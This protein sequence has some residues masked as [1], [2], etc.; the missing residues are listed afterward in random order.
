MSITLLCQI[1]LPVIGL[2][3]PLLILLG[4][5]GTWL[6]LALAGLAE[7]I[8]EPRLFGTPVLVIAVALAVAGEVWEALSSSVRARRAGAGRRGS[9]GALAGG[10]G[11]ALLGTML[12]PIPVVGT[13]IG[14]GLGAFALSSG[15]ERSGGKSADSA[16]RIGR[17]AATGHMIGLAGK[18]IAGLVV[19]VM[20]VTALYV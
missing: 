14:G 2:A 13:L 16:F 15:L 10:I 7:W 8:T 18:L 19:Y 9:I 20:L 11:G 1:F 4:L 17:A 3:G 6:L 5:P 12:I